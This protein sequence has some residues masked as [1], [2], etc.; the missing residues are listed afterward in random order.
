MTV[1]TETVEY[2]GYRII[3]VEWLGQ[4]Q[5]SVI[6]TSL[7]LP[8]PAGE[9]QCPGGTRMSAA[10]KVFIGWFGPRGLATIVFAILVLDAR[11]P[12]NDTV[13]LAAG[14]TVLLIVIAHGVTANA[15]VKAIG[16]RREETA[17]SS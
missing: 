9:Q 10:D 17:S 14:S 3:A 7:S 1:R 11:L 2:Q 5:A 4:R 8:R 16:G 12:G 6:P 15:L 13:M